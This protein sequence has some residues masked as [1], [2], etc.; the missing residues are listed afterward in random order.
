[1]FPN[2]DEL[3]QHDTHN[4]GNAKFKEVTHFHITPN[5]YVVC[6]VCGVCGVWCVRSKLTHDTTNDTTRAGRRS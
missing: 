5:G 1:M 4:T 2:P 3:T 6:G